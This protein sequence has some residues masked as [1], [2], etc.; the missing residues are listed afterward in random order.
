MSLVLVV[1]P[2]QITQMTNTDTVTGGE[3]LAQARVI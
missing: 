1:Q 3:G 2:E